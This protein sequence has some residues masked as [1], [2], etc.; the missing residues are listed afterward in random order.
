MTL[1]VMY[2]ILLAVCSFCQ[3][4]SS[5]FYPRCKSITYEPLKDAGTMVKAAIFAIIKNRKQ[6]KFSSLSRMI[7]KI[8]L[9]I[10]WN[11][12]AAGAR[13]Q[14]ESVLTLVIHSKRIRWVVFS[15]F[16]L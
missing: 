6:S 1:T 3:S 12:M 9:S 7:I 10:Q 4:C 13:D 14:L 11:T 8:W 2:V 5:G 15:A 16:F